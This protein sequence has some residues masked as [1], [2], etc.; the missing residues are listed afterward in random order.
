MLLSKEAMIHKNQQRLN[1]GLYLQKAAF[2]SFSIHTILL[3][4]YHRAM[5]AD[6]FKKAEDFPSALDRLYT[7]ITVLRSPGG[8]PWD[9]LQTNKS[10]TISLIDE[11]YEYLDG[12]IRKD[13]A[14]EREEIGDVMINVFMN[15][16]IHE[17]N[18]DFRP[19]DA[20]NEV[21]DKLIRR[22]PH[23]FGNEKAENASE[24][25][26]LWNSVKENVEG[27]KDKAESF[28]SHI[29]SSLPPLEESYEIQKKLKKVGF[30]WPEVSGVITK[31]EEELEEVNQ[32][33]AEGDEDHLEMELGD[34][35]FSVVN[36]CRF[37]KIRP[38]IALHRCNEKVKNRFQR[39]FT[40]ASEQGIPIDKD[41]VNEM[42]ELWEKAK[43]EEN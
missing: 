7:I 32:A 13:I 6:Y 43:K 23:V 28:F 25:L 19:E 26:S 16:Y 39:L 36:L 1:K 35:L 4:K 20:V 34:L 37:M 30:D 3:G 38:N 40:M 9:R 21:C 12:V 17:E 24:V 11:S 33:I 22:H 2:A 10:T 31:V 8:C 29:P 14:S 18:N 41:H 5:V 42:N 27:H 15:L